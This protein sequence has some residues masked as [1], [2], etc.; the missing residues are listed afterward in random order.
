MQHTQSSKKKLTSVIIFFLTTFT[1]FLMTK[2]TNLINKSFR[3][4]FHDAMASIFISLDGANIITNALLQF[5][6]I[7]KGSS[8]ISLSSQDQSLLVDLSNYISSIIFNQGLTNLS[9][10]LLSNELLNVSNQSVLIRDILSIHI[11]LPKVLK[12]RHISDFKGMLKLVQS[13]ILLDFFSTHKLINSRIRV[14]GISNIALA[15]KPDWVDEH[16]FFD[17]GRRILDGVG[18]K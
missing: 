16:Q 7:L 18:K 1:N 5:Q 4:I 17:F 6:S 8:I 9:H 14:S 12:I 15:M 3:L 2:F 11:V 10:I 13:Q